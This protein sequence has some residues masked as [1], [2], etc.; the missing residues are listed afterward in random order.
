MH[1]TTGYDFMNDVDRRAGRFLNAERAITTTFTR[2][3]GHSLHF[4]HLVY[5]KKRQVMRL[6][7]AND[8]NVLGNMLDR[9]SEQ[10]RWFRDF[11]LQAL[12]SARSAKPLPAFRFIE[13]IWPRDRPV[14]EADRA[15]I[16]RAIAAAKRRNPGIE[17]SVFN[18]L[19][20]HLALPFPGEPGRSKRA[21]NT[22]T[23]F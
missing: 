6:S 17:E 8:V 23:S 3:I 12:D 2:F 4:G 19:A 9:L 16:E 20:R 21:P 14:S 5:A 13:L 15:V 10:N 1:G 18:F 11:T 7:L 22:S